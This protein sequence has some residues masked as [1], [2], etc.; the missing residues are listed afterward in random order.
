MSKGR[1]ASRELWLL[2]N[3]V[4]AAY[5]PCT[6]IDAKAKEQD[7]PGA[8][9]RGEGGER[10]EVGGEKSERESEECTLRVTNCLV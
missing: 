2:G 10:A 3:G 4:I 1:N 5:G 6:T 8:A 9:E 7:R